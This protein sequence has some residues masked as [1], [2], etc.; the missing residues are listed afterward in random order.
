MHLHEALEFHSFFNFIVTE[1]LLFELLELQKLDALEGV[2][3]FTFTKAVGFVF[4]LLTVAN[5]LALFK[6]T[7][8]FTRVFLGTSSLFG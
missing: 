6:V 4:F 8:V 3:F 5:A 7:L 1:S 2:E